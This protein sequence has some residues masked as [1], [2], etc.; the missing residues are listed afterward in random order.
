MTANKPT[1]KNPEIAWK[2]KLQP[3]WPIALLI[4]V[5]VAVYVNSLPN[6][7]VFDDMGTIVENVHIKHLGKNFPSFFSRSYYKIA[8]GEASYRPVATL[9][10]YLLYA[11]F[12]LNPFGYHL[13]S[14]ALHIFNVVLVYLLAKRLLG[15]KTFSLTAGLLFACHPVL[16]EVV[17]CIS[18]ND[19]LLATFFFFLSLLLYLKL[20][21][22]A[23]K[24]NSLFLGLSLLFYLL[25]LLSKEM[26]LT[27]PMVIFVYD[28]VL[29][30]AGD[31]PPSLA[32]ALKTVFQQK[33]YYLG[34]AAITLFYLWIRF[35]ALSNPQGAA[36]PVWGSLWERIIYLPVLFFN[37]IKLILFPLVLNAD[38]VFSYPSR[39]FEIY[40]MVAFL[41]SAGLIIFSFW[42]Y[43]RIRVISFGIWWF[44]ITLL[45][46]Y[47]II[48]LF[49]PLA[50]RYLY[51]PLFGFCLVVAATMSMAAKRMP[52]KMITVFTLLVVFIIVIFYATI[53]INRN[54]DWRDGYSLWTQ[55]LKT[56]PDSVK[57]HGNLARVYMDRGLVEKS[58][59]EIKKT[60][61][62]NPKGYKAYYNLGVLLAKQGLFADAVRAYKKAIEKNPAYDNAHFNLANL[63]KEQNMLA[64]AAQE[65]QKTVQLD[66]QDVEA[67][68]NLG[69][70]YAIRGNLE[71]AVSQWEKV[72]EIEPDN[73]MARDNILKARKLLDN[74]Q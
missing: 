48:P 3:L 11:L 20:N 68:N 41:L 69:V 52:G 6:G 8:H 57:A 29:K 42:I 21:A 24:R 17:D 26:A 27:L 73:Q 67:R 66:G 58:L 44:F 13:F 19:D 62:L 16:T 60:I 65:Y 33:Y 31:R 70:I 45:P 50:E 2:Q 71:D 36:N 12:G 1:Q 39:F 53:T 7:F 14:L 38:Y 30:K 10:Y 22:G 43:K 47:N 9:S 28:W 49:N 54:R 25:G 56:S 74:P 63:Y 46:V 64:E 18:Y 23:A 61:G 34:Y 37:Y 32:T 35:W 5:T 15:N 55:T 51:I 72:L 4:A 40:N 59:R